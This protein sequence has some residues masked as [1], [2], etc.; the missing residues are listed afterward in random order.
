MSEILSGLE[1]RAKLLPFVSDGHLAAL[2]WK[3]N[4]G[5]NHVLSYSFKAFLS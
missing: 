4:S 1:S 3:S 2:I 5:K